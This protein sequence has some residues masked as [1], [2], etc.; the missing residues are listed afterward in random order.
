M[1]VVLETACCRFGETSEVS[2]SKN[3]LLSE[4]TEQLPR[5]ECYSMA[6]RVGWIGSRLGPTNWVALGPGETRSAWLPQ[7]ASAAFEEFKSRR[8]SCEGQ[9]ATDIRSPT[10]N[11]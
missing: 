6:S 11:W 7:L 2:V 5:K 8:R 10:A 1:G 9:Q 4:P 3:L